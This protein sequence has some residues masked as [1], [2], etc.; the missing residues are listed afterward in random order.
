MTFSQNT[1]CCYVG[2]MQHVTSF[3]LHKLKHLSVNKFHLVRRNLICVWTVNYQELFEFSFSTQNLRW[4]LLLC[5]E[6]R[7]VIT[8]LWSVNGSFSA[9]L[10]LLVVLFQFS[11]LA[12]GL[13]FAATCFKQPVSVQSFTVKSCYF[14]WIVDQLSKISWPRTWGFRI[15]SHRATATNDKGL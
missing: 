4:P 10:L 6:I 12:E 11:A 1:F 2:M 3:K 13:S 8:Y 14:A 5:S 15:D 7:Y 9:Q